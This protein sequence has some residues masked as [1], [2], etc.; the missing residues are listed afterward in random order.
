MLMH[1]RRQDLDAF[2]KE[3]QSL[4]NEARSSTN[5]YGPVTAHY[6]SVMSKL[7]K[8]KSCVDIGCGIGSVIEDLAGTGAKFTGLTIAPNEVEIGNAN[9]KKF[10]IYPHCQILQANCVKSV[11]LESGS[12]DAAYAIYALKYF[13]DI[14]PIASEVSRILKPNGLFLVYD[15]MKTDK[16]DPANVIH[17][18]LLDGLSYACGMPN[19]HSRE[20]MVASI[21][22]SGFHLLEAIN[23][24][25]ESGQPFYYCFSS[26]ALFMWLVRS[27]IIGHLI[28]IGQMLRILPSGFHFF[29]KIFLSGTVNKIVRAGEL[30]ILSGAEILLFQKSSEMTL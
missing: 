13:P 23:L 14:K 25:D 11:P 29:N 17:R 22:N 16:Y 10:G 1:F 3:H 30:G 19:L 7:E 9:F 12:Q 21:E 15:L 18:K 20:E 26:S 8:G 28:K 27:P 5:D 2:C 4:Y 24:S 6:Y